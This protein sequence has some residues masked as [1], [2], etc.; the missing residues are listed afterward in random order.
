M[1]CDTILR[2]CD[3]NLSCGLTDRKSEVGKAEMPPLR[4]NKRG[5]LYYLFFK[6][7]HHIYFFPN[8]Q[9]HHIDTNLFSILLLTN[10]SNVFNR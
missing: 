5:A 7:M 8:A 3:S 6:G 1:L 2:Q 4:K 10:N 9:R